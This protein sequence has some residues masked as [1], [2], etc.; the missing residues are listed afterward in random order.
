ML[1]PMTSVGV[2]VNPNMPHELS[3]V[4]KLISRVMRNLQIKITGLHIRYEDSYAVPGKLISAGIIVKSFSMLVGI[5][6]Q[7][8]LLIFW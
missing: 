3:F 1:N 6:R 7:C 5:S 4:D 2:L 8:L